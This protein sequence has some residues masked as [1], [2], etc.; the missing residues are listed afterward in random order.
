MLV[1]RLARRRV[2]FVSGGTHGGE[3][4]EHPEARTCSSAGVSGPRMDRRRPVHWAAESGVGTMLRQSLFCVE[5]AV[6]DG[7]H[8]REG[9]KGLHASSP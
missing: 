1:T 7:M 2:D 6:E 4:G 5:L 8:E 3:H 9:T